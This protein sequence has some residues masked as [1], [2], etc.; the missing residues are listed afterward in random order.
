MAISIERATVRE[1][2]C[3]LCGDTLGDV[4]LSAHQRVFRRAPGCPPSTGP[5]ERL[6]CPRCNG[7]V[8]LEGAET[9][10]DWSLL[11]I[12]SARPVRPS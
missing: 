4:L 3:F 1:V 11:P 5:L 7:P 6:R 9:T 12:R 8:Y 10:T 2:K